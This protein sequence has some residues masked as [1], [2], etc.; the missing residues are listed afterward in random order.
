[1]L[2]TEW[3]KPDYYAWSLLTK[4]LLE[5]I[6]LASACPLQDLR[7][8]HEV[9]HHGHSEPLLQLRREQLKNSVVHLVVG[10]QEQQ[11]TETS[12]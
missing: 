8:F 6:L 9:S 1:M 7:I 10:F 3:T 11:A 12:Q 2:I 4:L 5:E